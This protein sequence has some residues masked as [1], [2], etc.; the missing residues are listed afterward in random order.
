[1]KARLSTIL[2]PESQSLRN[3]VRAG[4]AVK[5]LMV[6]V[7]LIARVNLSMRTVLSTRQTFQLTQGPGKLDWTGR[8]TLLKSMS[9][10]LEQE[11]RR[12]AKMESRLS[13]GARESLQSQNLS[14]KL[15][16]QAT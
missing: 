12:S 14:I 11:T 2:R 16:L 3:V 1:M 13:Q 7:K 6:A 5:L 8:E 15:T 9:L 10:I 4:P